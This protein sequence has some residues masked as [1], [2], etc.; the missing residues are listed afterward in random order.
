MYS[1]LVSVLIPNSGISALL[2]CRFF[3][4]VFVYSFIAQPLSCVVFSQVQSPGA[5]V[6]ESGIAS[7][8]DDLRAQLANSEAGRKLLESQLSEANSSV[9]LLREEGS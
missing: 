6:N 7:E 5:A 9:A 3:I 2:F 4:Y 8:V 1:T